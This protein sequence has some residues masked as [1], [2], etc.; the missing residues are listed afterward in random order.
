MNNL[1]CGINKGREGVVYASDFK[2]NTG[3][4]RSL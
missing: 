3:N 1:M 4:R 2:G